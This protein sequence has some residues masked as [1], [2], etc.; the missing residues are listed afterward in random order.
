MS[1]ATVEVK[2]ELELEAQPTSGNAL[3]VFVSLGMAFL[4]IVA[5]LGVAKS[6]NL[7]S[8]SNLLYVALIFYSGAAALYM[9]FGVTGTE[10][11]VKFAS[12]ATMIGLVANT[13]AAGHRWYESGHP[14][15][16]SLY[17]MLLSFVWTVALLTLIWSA[18][19][20][21]RLSARSPCPWRW[22]V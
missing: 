15:F 21:S 19:I 2:T 14:P 8:E 9:G 10:R 1:R 3:L 7:F 13:L 20:R 22:S 12:I 17:E 11:Y 5:L 6:G 16:A 4:L 18:N